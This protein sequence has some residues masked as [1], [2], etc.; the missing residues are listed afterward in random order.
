[1]TLGD[2]ECDGA[3]EAAID[4]LTKDN[5]GGERLVSVVQ[6][7]FSNWG[8][9]EGVTS[10]DDGLFSKVVSTAFREDLLKASMDVC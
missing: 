9:L 4:L 7:L 3:V 1:M 5:V 10:N 2:I 6:S 8:V